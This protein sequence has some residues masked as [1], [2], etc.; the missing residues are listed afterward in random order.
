MPASRA[1]CY[2][3]I[4]SIIIERSEINLTNVSAKPGD[5][6][7]IEIGYDAPQ[8]GSEYNYTIAIFYQDKNETKNESAVCT[9]KV[10]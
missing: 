3:N 9:G 4:T 10:V 6:V 7:A 2:T 1:S 5:L 8:K